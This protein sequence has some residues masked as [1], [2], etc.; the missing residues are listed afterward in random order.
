M[1]RRKTNNRTGLARIEGVP[2]HDVW[3]GFVCLKCHQ[4]NTIDIGTEL[5]DPQA[6]FETGAW[7]CGKCGY[8][9]S[10]NSD[11]PFRIWP[12]EFRDH[13]SLRAERFWIGFFRIAT[14]HPS[15][16]WKQ[17]N[18]CG[19][20]L[21]FEAFSKHSGWGAL[22]R[23]MECRCCKGAIN[24]VLNP[25]RTP[26]QLHESSV[27]RRIADLL[28]EGQNQSIDLKELFHR[29]ENKCFK[30][31]RPLAFGKRGSWEVDHILPS[32]YL[33]PLTRENAALLCA[34]CNN[35][36]HGRWPRDYYS[37]NELIALSRIT[38]GDLS[39]LANPAPL[40]N[41]HINVDACVSRFLRVRERSNLRKRLVEL[42]ALL[43]D[44][45]LAEKLSAENKK[46]LGLKN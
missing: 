4:L 23:Q 7:P 28:L 8:L 21:P 5:L 45:R 27:K 13:G 31:A 3:V 37:N 26:Q 16:Y 46:I 44:Y 6:A 14:E 25:R 29:F 42:K 36:K 40:V 11:L 18:T 30:C 38:G 1:A 43:E 33:Y 39:L 2:V 35:T 24:A 19:R 32:K 22:E 34:G 10:R 15:S 12:K 20:V 17:C 41:P 9:H